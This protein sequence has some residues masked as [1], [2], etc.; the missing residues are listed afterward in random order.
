MFRGF[1]LVLNY[2]TVSRRVVCPIKGEIGGPWLA[3]LNLP[4]LLWARP[5]AVINTICGEEGI[6]SNFSS[7]YHLAEMSPRQSSEE[8]QLFF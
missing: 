7:G 4:L 1:V 8:V 2:R 5:S 6:P 3:D